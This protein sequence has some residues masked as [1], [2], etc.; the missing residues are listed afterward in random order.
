MRAGVYVPIIAGADAGSPAPGVWRSTPV[1]AA[2]AAIPFWV[3]AA[4]L[5]FNI[6]WPTKLVI[7]ATLALAIAAPVHGLLAAAAVAPLGQL[8]AAFIDDPDFRIGE[9]MVVAFLLAWI[10]RPHADRRGPRAPAAAAAWLLACAIVASMATVAWRLRATSAPTD[11]VRHL[12][13]MYFYPSA[14]TLGI[15]DA[16]RLLEMLAL[17]AVTVILFRERPRIAVALPAIL[18]ASATAAAISSVLVWYRI[19]IASAL[20]RYAVNGYRIS[21]HVADVN[22]AGSYFAMVVC[23]LVGMAARA[24]GA[25]RLPWIAAA[26]TIAIGLWFS[27]SRSAFGSVGLAAAV[28]LAAIATSRLSRGARAAIVGAVF[29]A[30]VVAAGVVAQRV[31]AGRTQRGAELRGQFTTT[32]FRM[33]EARPLLGV[34][35][36]QYARLSPLFMSAELAWTYGAENAHDYFLQIAAELG[37]VGFVLFVIWIAGGFAIVLRAL[38]R[39]PA[40]A[41]LAG[42]ATGLAA[43]LG[44]CATGHPLLVGEATYPFALQLGLAAALAESTLLNRDPIGAWAASSVAHPKRRR[45]AIAAGAAAIA[46]GALV[47]AW[48]GPLGL[49]RSDSIDGFYEWETAEDGTRFRWTKE[50]ASVI[51]PNDVGRVRIPIRV[52]TDRPTI[53]PM[54]V[55]V[56]IAGSRPSRMLVDAS[57]SVLEADLSAFDPLAPV[58]RVNL[59]VERTW[60]PALYVA[61]SA[62]MRPVGVQVGEVQSIR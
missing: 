40:D 4:S 1:R 48:R 8:A 26:A 15:V 42:A 11:A 6:G 46:L 44:T 13:Y 51:V 62:E 22:A 23:L 43:F 45:T 24:R 29:V 34:G 58:R 61:G 20:A 14:N 54:P 49:A 50:F 9:A 12:I 37:I 3:V 28:A 16:A 36:G 56:S 52:P 10:A 41:R 18:V 21:G 39:T 38:R 35:V 60:R 5:A 33:I 25:A 17:A 57:W 2:L 7:A 27:E 55:Y 19:G 59:K 30:V 32:T 53:A 31:E 47:S